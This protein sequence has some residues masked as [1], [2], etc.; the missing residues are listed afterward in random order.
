MS[1]RDQRAQRLQEFDDV[2]LQNGQGPFT[3]RT[4]RS[5]LFI[6]LYRD[7]PL[8]RLPFQLLQALQDLDEHMGNVRYRHHRPGGWWPPHGL[9][10]F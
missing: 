8:F 6:M 10:V 3:A 9:T 5:A 4:L 2:L 7:E 1:P